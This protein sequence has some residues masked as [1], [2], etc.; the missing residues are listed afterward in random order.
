MKGQENMSNIKTRI[1][2]AEQRLNLDREPIIC[3]IVDFG[4]KPLPPDEQRG[5][6]L[7]RH[8]RY[9]DIRNDLACGGDQR[10]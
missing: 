3:A 1:E 6:V 10:E 2:K 7:V 8:V 9:S 4:D 5:N